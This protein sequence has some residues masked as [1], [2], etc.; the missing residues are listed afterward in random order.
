LNAQ[1]W[2]ALAPLHALDALDG[3]DLVLF[4]EELKGSE[5]LRA[6]ASDYREATTVLA[7][8]LE[9]L[10]P[11]PAVKSR[12]LEAVTPSPQRSAPVFTRVFWAVAAIFLVSLLVRSLISPVEPPGLLL[13][14][15]R[16]APSAKGRIVWRGRSVELTVSGLPALPE[17]QVYQLW[18]LGPG[19]KPIPAATFSVDETGRLHGWDTLKFAV[20]KGDKFAITREPEGGS[21]SP[22]MPLYVKPA[23]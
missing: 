22:S 15:D 21:L 10:T 14:G 20:A 19:P 5:P 16:P 9:P 13:E 6:L 23:P 11:S 12:L 17:G 3:E 4:A 7:L 18:H 2:D 1:D 8:S